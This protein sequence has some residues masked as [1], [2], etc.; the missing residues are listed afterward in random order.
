MN[1]IRSNRDKSAG[2]NYSRLTYV[3]D[4]GVDQLFRF[5]VKPDHKQNVGDDRF[6]EYM[7]EFD[8]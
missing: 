7:V 2:D 4:T 5:L 8:Y 3:N 1:Y 6:G